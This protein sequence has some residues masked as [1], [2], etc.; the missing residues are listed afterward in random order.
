MTDFYYFLLFYAVLTGLG[1]GIVYMLP[2]KSAWSFFPG[3]K[4]TIGGLILASHSFGAIGWS[5][6][7]ATSIN[8]LNEA[9]NLQLN[10]GNTVELLFSPQSGP[11]ANVPT[12]LRTVFYVE[13]TIFLIAVALMNK[14]KVIKFE[15]ELS[16]TL[17]DREGDEHLTVKN[18]I[19]ET[20]SFITRQTSATG[21]EI[22][23]LERSNSLTNDGLSSQG[24]S[25][26]E[27]SSRSGFTASSRD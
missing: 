11:V 10:V 25:M 9:P 2:L 6:F 5:F 22:D 18:K 4:G 3:K 20:D 24:G 16:E 27:L 15:R 19:Y 12:T 23:S 13:L 7:T 1:Y 14:K 8:P 21:R 17:I 26:S